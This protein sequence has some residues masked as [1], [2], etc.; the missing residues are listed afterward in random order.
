MSAAG[1][2]VEGIFISAESERLPEPVEEVEVLAGKGIRGDRYF[3]PE[4]RE[5]GGR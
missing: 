3:V 5:N 1:G 2:S 4:G